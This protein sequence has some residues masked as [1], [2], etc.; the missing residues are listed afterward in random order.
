MEAEHEQVSPLT[1]EQ[2]KEIEEEL[3]AVLRRQV[4]RAGPVPLPSSDFW[5]QV[6]ELCAHLEVE[7]DR[8]GRAEGFSLRSQTAAKRQAGIR[9]AAA[10]LARKRMVALVEHAAASSLTSNPFP[11]DGGQRIGV[12]EALDW[13]QHDPSERSFHQQLTSDLERFKHDVNW[14]AIQYGS[15]G[16]PRL[17][18]VVGRGTRQLDDFVEEPGGITGEGPPEIMLIEDPHPPAADSEEED[19]EERIAR[20]DGY[21]ELAGQFD[22]RRDEPAPPIEDPEGEE[23]LEAPAS[24]VRIRVTTQNDE[25]FV[26]SAGNDLLLNEGDVHMLEPS[27]AK[28]LIDLEFAVEVSL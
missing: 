18:P 10:D 6:G 23:G 28:A 26:D 11:G 3:Y 21:P 14:D 12:L 20:I 8:L 5:K 19:E 16:T 4:S 13:S 27:L 1:T 2:A 25:P 7:V 9:R 22:E 24:L 17:K 15:L